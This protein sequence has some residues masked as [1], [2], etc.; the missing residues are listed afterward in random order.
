MAWRDTVADMMAEPRSSVKY[1]NLFP[2]SAV[3]RCPMP[4]EFATATRIV[5]GAGT[6]SQV[7]DAAQAMGRRVLL[8]TGV[9]PSGGNA[10]RSA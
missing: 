8:V 2:K 7:A 6:R 3:G 4:F 5:F 1:S 10:A 9:T